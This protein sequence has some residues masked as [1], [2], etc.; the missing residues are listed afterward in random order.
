MFL[1]FTGIVCVPIDY[2]HGEMISRQGDYS[3]GS[4]ADE[5]HH[6]SFAVETALPEMQSDEYD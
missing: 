5:S 2:H 1:Q 4:W 6:E 3:N